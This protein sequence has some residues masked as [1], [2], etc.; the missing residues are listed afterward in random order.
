ME[1]NNIKYLIFSWILFNA[2]G[3]LNYNTCYSNKIYLYKHFDFTG[4]AETI[5]ILMTIIILVISIICLI[6]SI[7]AREKGVD[8]LFNKCMVAVFIIYSIL[9]ICTYIY[10]RSSEENVALKMQSDIEEYSK[11]TKQDQL[12]KNKVKNKNSFEEYMV[13]DKYYERKK[14]I[15][16]QIENS[17]KIERYISMLFVNY[18]YEHYGS[19]IT[20]EVEYYGIFLELILIGLF[21][22][23]FYLFNMNA[24]DN[25]KVFYDKT[26][27]IM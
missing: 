18:S 15:I 26:N 24:K 21:G 25:T 1:K 16:E 22:A 9:S 13:N 12:N 5:Q 3:Y 14:E 20:D 17:S 11:T 19:T 23:I 2:S 6:K 10:V 27:Y 7:Q 8:F 4:I